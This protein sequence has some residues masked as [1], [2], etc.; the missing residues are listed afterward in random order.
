[1]IN[2]QQKEHKKMCN[3][4]GTVPHHSAAMLLWKH[5]SE[6]LAFI[7]ASTLLANHFFVCESC[8]PV[9]NEDRINI[10]WNMLFYVI[11]NT[12]LI[13]SFHCGLIKFLV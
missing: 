6:T 1:M 12:F 2:E 11:Y 13:L 3:E 7:P 4:K 8:N 5:F 9:R 10:T